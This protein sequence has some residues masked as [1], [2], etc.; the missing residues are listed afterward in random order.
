VALE[1]EQFTYTDLSH[2]I[3]DITAEE[4]GEVMKSLGLAPSD[5]ELND[6]IAE[7]DVNNNGS[8]D[9]NGLY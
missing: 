6:L 9:F 7:A 4:L 1:Y 3:G 5:S 2:N 8:I